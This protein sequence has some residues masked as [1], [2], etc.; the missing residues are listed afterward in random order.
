MIDTTTRA[1]IAPSSTGTATRIAVVIPCFRVRDHVLDVIG[2]IGP[3]VDW[4]FVVDDACP[5]GSGEHVRRHCHDPRVSVIVHERNQG[6]GGAVVT[7]YRAAL[8]IEAVA[9]AKLDGDGQMDPALLARFAQPVLDGRADYAKGNRFHSLGSTRGMPALRLF[10]N[11]ALSF[12]SKL[13]TGYW[14]VFDPT[15]GYT[16]I[17]RDLLALLPLDAIAKRY[18]FESDLLH[19][20][21]LVRGVVVDVPMQAVYGDEPSSL[22]PLRTIVPFAFGHARNF[23]RRVVYQYFVRGFSLASV[24]LALGLAML[25]FG[26]GFG[27]WHWWQSIAAAVPATAGTVMV[28]GLSIIVG[29]QLVLSWLAFDIASEPRTPVGPLLG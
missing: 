17:R 16:V 14:Q 5:E 20:L 27:G 29:M 10:G 12:L 28:A 23:V 26:A 7:G 15:N 24:E 25:G 21:G 2:R 11:A 8:A 4:I 1:P 6:V 18:F 3:E 9:V 19:H 13:S 22:S